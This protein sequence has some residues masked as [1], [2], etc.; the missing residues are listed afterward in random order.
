M[1]DIRVHHYKKIE[2]MQIYQHYPWLRDACDSLKSLQPGGANRH[3]LESTGFQDLV[4]I[5][6][7]AALYDRERPLIVADYDQGCQLV[8]RGGDGIV[9]RRRYKF[10]VM[11]EGSTLS[12]EEK[13]RAVARARAIADQIVGRL[14]KHHFEGVHGLQHLEVDG[15]EIADL[16]AT[17][18]G[19]QGVAARYSVLSA[20]TAKYDPNQW[21]D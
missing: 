2:T 20:R 13:N 10:Y 21:N 1:G 7:G 14:L 19:L 8:D 3:L 6:S 15:I 12:Y 4:T 17:G 9:E 5:L 18:D 16:G 11:C